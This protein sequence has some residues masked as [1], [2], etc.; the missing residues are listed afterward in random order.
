MNCVLSGKHANG[1]PPLERPAV[2]HSAR[3]Y[4]SPKAVR[5]TTLKAK[6]LT[7]WLARSRFPDF[8]A[9]RQSFW[10]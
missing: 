2:R 8:S 4:V 5:M 3:V 10:W 9:F 7:K 6:P 1:S